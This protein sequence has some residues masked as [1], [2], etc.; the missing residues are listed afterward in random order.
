MKLF[1]VLAIATVAI[2]AADASF[3][4]E[5]VSPADEAPV[6]NLMAAVEHLRN[7]AASHMSFHVQRISKHA[8]LLPTSSN[9]GDHW[10]KTEALL[11]THTF[12]GLD[13]PTGYAQVNGRYC[14]PRD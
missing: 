5:A 1:I 7:N 14:T 13:C 10:K 11:D 3:E 9:C 6:M 8:E 12:N 4:D 2:C